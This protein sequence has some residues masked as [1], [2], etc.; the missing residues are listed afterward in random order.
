MTQKRWEHIKTILLTFLILLSF[1]L[2]GYLIFSTPSFEESSDGYLRPPFIGEE[3]NNQQSV[4]QLAAPFQLITHY[5]GNH[6][7]TLPQDQNFDH[8][9]EMIREAEL[10]NF[11]EIKPTPE[12]WETI[13]GESVGVELH[14]LHDTTIGQL[15][16]FFKRTV[17]REQPLIKDQKKIGRI[18]FF[19]QPTSNTIDAWFISDETKTVIQAETFQINAQQLDRQIHQ[20]AISSKYSLIPYPTNKRA[21]WNKENEKVPF[22]RIIYLP[23]TPFSMETLTYNLREI[24]IEHM[25]QWLFTD[26][27]VAPIQLNN[28]ESLY[29][30]ND[31]N[32]YNDQI[33]TY[34]KQKNTMVYTNAPT[35]TENQPMLVREELDEINQFI[36]RHRG[37]TNIYRLDQIKTEDHANE[38]IFRL[39]VNHLPVYWTPSETSKMIDPDIIQFRVIA[40]SINKYSRSLHFLS[41]E[42]VNKSTTTMPDQ[43]EILALLKQHKIN[44]IQIKRLYPSYQAIPFQG[45]TVQL[46][47]IWTVEMNDGKIHFLSTSQKEEG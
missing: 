1:V 8:L 38:Y 7:L 22:T 35:K 45:Q 9:Y 11:A 37:W 12:Q 3:K 27:S 5:Q 26:P 46:T 2:T 14:F 39:F 32:M 28:N 40:G 42:V 36:Q 33:I 43:N 23:R 18:I 6:A 31:P 19:I 47:P 34:N 21:P 29:M 25:K 13:F 16:S 41:K 4:Y 24:D 17:F 15:D 44:L 10:K 20:A 30:Y